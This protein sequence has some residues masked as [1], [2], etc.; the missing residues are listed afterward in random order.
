MD[1]ATFAFVD[2]IDSPKRFPNG[3]AYDGQYMW[4]ADNQNSLGIDSIY[5]ID[6]NCQSTSVA[7]YK[8]EHDFVVYPNPTDGIF[9]IDLKKSLDDVS[10]TILDLRGKMIQSQ[11]FNNSRLLNFEINASPGVY[12]VMVESKD[13][14]VHSRLVKK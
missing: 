7:E 3:L 5:Q 13:Q 12:I 11:V 10:V 6:L 1:T 8:N 9:T 4:I 2:T 14:K